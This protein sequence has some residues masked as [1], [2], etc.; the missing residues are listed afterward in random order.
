VTTQVRERIETLAERASEGTLTDE[1]RSEYEA[2][3]HV[4]DLI[5]I[6]KLKARQGLAAGERR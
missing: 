2:L 3:I 1:E 4:A 6:L 5:S